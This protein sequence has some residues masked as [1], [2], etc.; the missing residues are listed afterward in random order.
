[1][2]RKTTTALIVLATLAALP[3]A[4]FP[5]AGDASSRDERTLAED[6]EVH[7][8]MLS[9]LRRQCRHHAAGCDRGHP[10]HGDAG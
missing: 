2:N 3:L 8:S 9:G 7:E 4:A 1:M 5:L 10:E 6:A